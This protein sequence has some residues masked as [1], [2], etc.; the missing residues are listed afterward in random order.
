MAERKFQA[1][2]AGAEVSD[3]YFDREGFVFQGERLTEE[4]ADQ[5]PSTCSRRPG[6][7]HGTRRSPRRRP[8]GDPQNLFG[9]VEVDNGVALLA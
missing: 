8:L 9:H 7:Q 6:P 2:L 3:I 4:R 1:I 5:K